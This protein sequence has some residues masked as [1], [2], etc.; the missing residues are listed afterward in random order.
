MQYPDTPGDKSPAEK[1]DKQ[2]R[3]SGNNEHGSTGSADDKNKPLPPE[4]TTQ[5][6]KEPGRKGD[7]P[8]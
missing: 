6:D 1:S 8:A 2:G 3:T 7:Q 4:A 5:S